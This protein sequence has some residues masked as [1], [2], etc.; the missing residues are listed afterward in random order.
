M[1]CSFTLFF[2]SLSFSPKLQMNLLTMCSSSPLRQN[3]IMEGNYSDTNKSSRDCT[4]PLT[5]VSPPCFTASPRPR[6]GRL[7]SSGEAYRYRTLSP[8]VALV[9]W[10]RFFVLFSGVWGRFLIKG[11]KKGVC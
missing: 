7:D 3:Y 8:S 1:A 6:H 10:W 2:F 4:L 5:L 9:G 11:D